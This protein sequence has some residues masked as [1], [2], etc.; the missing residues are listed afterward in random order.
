MLL[1]ERVL[2]TSS[3][4]VIIIIIITRNQVYLLYRRSAFTWMLDGSKIM[5]RLSHI[6]SSYRSEL[7]RGYR[8]TVEQ[9]NT[10]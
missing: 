10:V 1:V 2:I 3:A 6:D 4:I 5:P 7:L 9:R 8:Y